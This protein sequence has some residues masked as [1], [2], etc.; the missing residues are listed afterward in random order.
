MKAH[1]S[2]DEW[3]RYQRQIA[4][5]ELNAAHQIKLK[6]TKLLY[7]G[8][9]GLGS[10]AL[11]YLAAAGIGHITITD[12]DEISH[13]NLHRQ[14]IYQD[15]E[16]GINKAAAAAK[17][18]QALNP[19]CDVRAL[20]FKIRHCEEGDNPTRQSRFAVLDCF[21]NARNDEDI[22][23]DLILDGSDNFETKTLL[24]AL[25]IATKTPLI[26]ASVN[27]FEGQAGIFAGFANNAPCY[28]C[29][30]PELPSDARNCNEAGI[31]GTSAGIVG[32][33]QAHLTLCYLLG[34]GDI[35]EGTILSM[36]LKN[37]RITKLQLPKDQN[38]PHCRGA[39]EEIAQ[40]K[41]EKMAEMF[42]MD[43]LKSKDHIIVDV[44]TDGEREADP[45]EGSLHMEI[46]TLPSHY[47]EL[48]TDKLLAFVCAGNVRSVKAA[49]F[50]TAMGY[51][52]VCILDKFSL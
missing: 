35:K 50:M 23:F 48:P 44:R 14:T 2:P 40:E 43:E 47:K 42:S 49:D 13:S 3:E 30:F 51:D 27:R 34:I 32:L 29:L 4:L 37:L 12:H 28:H 7:V 33:Y 10:A 11:P 1:L 31:L 9:G 46:S 39:T 21:A 19:H 45:I 25:S 16:A 41:E 8:A 24:N 18:L 38:C 15:S 17:Y 20:P 36:D 52:N 22:N 5:P 26:S 6:Q